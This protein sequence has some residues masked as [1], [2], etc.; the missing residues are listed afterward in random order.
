M[1]LNP[2]LSSFNN[3]IR[4]YYF[5]LSAAAWLVGPWAM[6]AAVILAVSLL[7]WRQ[8]AS[9]SARGVRRIRELLESIP[10]PADDAEDA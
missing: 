8:A 10:Q 9:S 2:A 3:G 4:G 7:A 5:A 6:I 1:V